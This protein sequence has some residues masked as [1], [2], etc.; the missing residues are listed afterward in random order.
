MHQIRAK[1]D[2]YKLAV[3]LIL[4]VIGIPIFLLSDLFPLVTIND[5]L[6]DEKLTDWYGTQV[7]YA[8]AGDRLH[9]DV[10][11]SGGSAKLRVDK[12]T[13][14]TVFEE[15]QGVLL[16]Y[17]IPIPSDE[18]YIVYIW[19]RAYPFP[20]NYVNLTGTITLKRVS[21]NFYPIGYIVVGLIGFGTVLVVASLISYI[22]ER[23]RLEQEK[24]LRMCPY[25]HRK[26]SVEKQ[27]CPFCG[28]DVVRSVEC[29]YCDAFFDRNLPKCPNC[30]AK[31]AKH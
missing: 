19:T 9:I 18:G 5:F 13:G 7:F 16:K 10:T 20:S 31:K 14:G 21:N 23:K 26:V 30:G 24:K 2:F 22:Q 27:V 28:F 11:V 29:K 3:G 25:C 6:V 4:I 17:E 15:V 8:K 1:L 12:Q